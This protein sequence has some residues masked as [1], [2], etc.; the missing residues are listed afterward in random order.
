MRI[1]LD[2][3]ISAHKLP[4]MLGA[5]IAQ[6]YN[7]YKIEYVT[8]DT[9]EL[10]RGDLFIALRGERFN[11]ENYLADAKNE[12]AYTVSTRSENT[13]FTVKDTSNSLSR[14]ANAYK[15]LLNIK[16]TVAITGSV[17]KSTTKE[18]TLKLLARKFKAHGTYKNL[19]NEIGVPLTVLSAK[20]DTEILI[21]EAGMNHSGE[22]KRISEC[23][24]PD[25]AVITNVGT[26]HIGN[27]GSRKKIAEA[28]EEILCGMEKPY[29]LAPA[30]DPYI[31]KYP[32]LKTV[33]TTNPSADFYL[34]S[35]DDKDGSVY[36]FKSKYNRIDG[37]EIKSDMPH[38]PKC[39]SF[40]LSVCSVL[41]MSNEEILSAVNSLDFDNGNQIHK[42][43]TLT[44]IDDSYNCSP[45]SAISS[46]NML[47]RT[48]G[49]KK[50]AVFGD[51]L[52]LG[53]FSEQLH[54]ELG[55]AAADAGLSKLYL[56]G[57]YSEF[58]KNG[59]LSGGMSGDKIFVNS[60]T[61]AP[62]KTAKQILENSQNETVLLKG[63]RKLKLERI[64]EILKEY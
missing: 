40:A 8:T 56:F 61:E 1:R 63:S 52:E 45:E 54:F 32:F 31:T 53:E 58:T 48:K 36:G 62:E 37:I 28:K 14:F 9:R 46:L 51:M 2:I 23:I 30:D 17:G 18:L 64:L 7:D 44:L 26:A 34:F 42:L 13:D 38:I 11:G 15:K 43:G 27:L 10:K 4:D 35:S 3:P 16:S 47:L 33:S 20:K 25:I 50:S 59:A 55:K 21:I 6:K 5:E 22:L 19:N 49:E 24:Q 57:I 29:L 41:N 12:G 39:L 60:N